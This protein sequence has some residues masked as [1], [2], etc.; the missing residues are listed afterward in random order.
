MPAIIA[1]PIL[2]MLVAM[3]V[4]LYVDGPVH[5]FSFGII[6]TTFVGFRMDDAHAVVQAVWALAA[7]AVACDRLRQGN[8]RLTHTCR[9]EAGGRARATNGLPCDSSGLDRRSVCWLSR[10]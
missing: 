9:S 3:A 10:S 1:I 5:W 6:A 8:G 4:E 7:L 2:L